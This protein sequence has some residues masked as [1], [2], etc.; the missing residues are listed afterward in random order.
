MEIQGLRTLSRQRKSRVEF[1]LNMSVNE[2]ND[3]TTRSRA[4][5]HY[6][7]N[8][9]INML[10]KHIQAYVTLVVPSCVMPTLVS[11]SINTPR[12]ELI[13]STTCS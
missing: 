9:D 2:A 3:P 7:D 4:G 13:A 5:K 1:T 12:R 11:Y 10:N 8:M 6:Q